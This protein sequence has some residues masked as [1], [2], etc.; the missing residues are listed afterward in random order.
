MFPQDLFGSGLKVQ[1]CPDSSICVELTP[2]P[3]FSYHNS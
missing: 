1:I 2:S 3:N